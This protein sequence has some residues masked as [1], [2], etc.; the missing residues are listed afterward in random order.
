ML[1]LAL[2]AYNICEMNLSRITILLALAVASAADT[3]LT[4]T[5]KIQRSAGGNESQQDC[6]ITQKDND[7]SGTCA[8]AD[9]ETVKITGKV[10]GKTV[11][12]TYKGDSPGGPVTVVYNGTI[13]S[14]TRIA[15]KVTAVEF[16]IE[17]D[18][19]ATRQ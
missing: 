8:A 11:T 16:S 1:T 9:R 17:G 6:A 18:F 14:P 10:S 12:W 13:E 2:S 7:L 19:T 4:G 3:S 15:G 5:W